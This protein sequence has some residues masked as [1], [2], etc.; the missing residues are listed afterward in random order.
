[1]LCV[2]ASLTA[3]LCGFQA[4]ANTSGLNQNQPIRLRPA[5]GII[6][7]QTVTVPI[8]PVMFGPPKLA[9][10]VIHSRPT[11]PMNNGIAPL[12]SQGTNDDR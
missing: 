1:M 7:P 11:V 6:T 9:S 12:L 2:M 5:T 3:M 4:A 8:L 10:V